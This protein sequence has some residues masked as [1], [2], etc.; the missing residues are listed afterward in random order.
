MKIKK[1]VVLISSMLFFSGSSLANIIA[2]IPQYPNKDKP[3]SYIID[4]KDPSE[5]MGE[6]AYMKFNTVTEGFET[7]YAI[8]ING[9]LWVK[10]KN[11]YGQMGLGNSTT[12]NEHFEDWKMVLKGLNITDIQ[13]GQYDA[14]A[15]NSNGEIFV[16][17]RN[18]IGN[19][20][21]G[22][23]GLGD[24]IDRSTWTKVSG[25]SNVKQVET[26][27]EHIIIVDSNGMM[28]MSGDSNSLSHRS[29]DTDG[30]FYHDFRPSDDVGFNYETIID[31]ASGRGLS[32]AID[33]NGYLW[34]TGGSWAHGST[35]YW[36]HDWKVMPSSKISNLK[37]IESGYANSYALDNNG[38]VYVS[39]DNE[40][41]QL[42]VSVSSSCMDYNPC[43][44]SSWL[45][46]GLSNIVD[47]RAGYQSGFALD[48]NGDMW[49]TGLNSR[50]APKFDS[51]YFYGELGLGKSA[52]DN[53][54]RWT[55]VDYL[56]KIKYLGQG[57]HSVSFIS[58]D[59]KIWEINKSTK[60]FE[61]RKIIDPEADSDGDGFLD[62]IEVE[63]GTN[64][65]GGSSKPLDT[66]GDGLLDYIDEDDDN[67]GFRDV[68][69][70]EAGSDP[71]DYNDV[72]SDFDGDGQIDIYDEDDDDDGFTD[73]DEINVFETNPF[74]PN[75]KPNVIKHL[76]SGGDVTIDSTTMYY[77]NGGSQNGYA[78]NYKNVIWKIKPKSGYYIKA[79]VWDFQ[80]KRGDSL[81]VYQDSE[82]T[83]EY[84][85]WTSNDYV[86]DEEFVSIGSDGGLSFKFN[87][88]AK[89]KGIGW[90]IL[91]TLHPLSGNDLDNDGIDDMID[92]DIDGDGFSNDLEIEHGYNPKDPNDKPSDNDKDGIIDEVDTDDDNDSFEDKI[93]IIF[94]S[95]PKDKNSTPDLS[96]VKSFNHFEGTKEITE[97]IYYYDQNGETENY[98]EN[99][100]ANLYVT[101]PDGYKVVATVVDFNM[102]DGYDSLTLLKGQYTGN[103][104][105]WSNSQKIVEM[106]G[107]DGLYN[108]KSFSSNSSDGSM[109]FN[110]NSDSSYQLDGWKLILHLEK[111]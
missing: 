3:P 70:I 23:L 46:T 86:Y 95:D 90:E 34:Y 35:Y 24:K 16:V 57:A 20:E 103:Y 62:Y 96:G 67:D 87:S 80:L 18:N 73:E 39:G 50:N 61:E 44:A 36:Q 32:L 60:L 54:N 88:D 40:Q 43:H 6:P 27:W 79:K 55:K 33:S 75:S 107:E 51:G 69:E 42:G 105:E 52:G 109:T 12:K 25:Y 45:D 28:R 9:N 37:K 97:P 17:G 56:P 66:D 1:N 64:P 11:T 53:I 14:I 22:L 81:T 72:P 13:A 15:T 89:Q 82:M 59:N 91:L 47:I 102:E 110:M 111:K 48:N 93:E 21:S 76:K 71:L 41:G 2:L 84:A 74:D 58:E 31:F 106:S 4:G 30:N 77:D 85:K 38:K 26:R 49:V 94:G 65:Q 92:D 101:A 83:K 29:Q 78:H 63:A 99:V 10:G 100:S 108:N 7:S 5:P 98:P 19:G 8:D 68:V 104:G